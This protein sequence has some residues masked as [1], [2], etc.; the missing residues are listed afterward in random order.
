MEASSLHGLT[1]ASISQLSPE[2]AAELLFLTTEEVSS[3]ISICKAKTA[4]AGTRESDSAG[5]AS[6]SSVPQESDSVAPTE[7]SAPAPAVQTEEEQQASVPIPPSPPATPSPHIPAPV[8]LSSEASV[9]ITLAVSPVPPPASEPILAPPTPTA[10]APPPAAVPTSAPSLADAPSSPRPDVASV[11]V[12][13]PVR[14]STPIVETVVATTDS[15]SSKS[16][17]LRAVHL[18]VEGSAN[19]ASQAGSAG[20]SPSYLRPTAATL[21]RSKREDAQPPP[22]PVVPVTPKRRTL[23]SRIMGST[24]LAPTANFLARMAGGRKPAPGEHHHRGSLCPCIS[25]T[26]GP[27]VHAAAAASGSLGPCITVLARAPSSGGPRPT[28]R[29]QPFTLTTELRPKGQPAMS[30]EELDMAEAKAFIAELEPKGQPAMRREELDMVEAKAFIAELEPK[31]QPA[32][33]WA[34]LDTAEAKVRSWSA[35]AGQVAATRRGRSCLGEGV[36]QRG[37]SFDDAGRAACHDCHRG[38]GMGRESGVGQFAHRDP[39]PTR[40]P[41]PLGAGGGADRTLAACLLAP[42]WTAILSQGPPDLRVGRAGARDRAPSPRIPPLLRARSLSLSSDPCATPEHAFRRNPVPR[43]IHESRELEF[44][45]A[46]S[47]KLPSQVCVPFHLA[48]LD[49]HTKKQAEI[50]AKAEELERREGEART[51]KARGF[52]KTLAQGVQTPPKPAPQAATTATAFVSASEKRSK[53]YTEVLE[54]V[55][56]AREAEANKDKL[57][58]D[59]ATRALEGAWDGTTDADKDKLAEEIASRSL[60]D[61]GLDQFRKTLEFKAAAM[62]DFSSPFKPSASKARGVTQSQEFKFSTDDRLGP[63]GLKPRDDREGAGLGHGV[64]DGSGYHNAFAAN[65]RSSRNGGFLRA[66]MP[67]SPAAAAAAAAGSPARPA[68]LLGSARSQPPTPPPAGTVVAAGSGSMRRRGGG[69]GGDHLTG[70]TG[71]RGRVLAPHGSGALGRLQPVTTASQSRLWVAPTGPPH[72]H[73]VAQPL[74]LCPVG[75]RHRSANY[76]S[77]ATAAGAAYAS[78][79]AATAAA[80]AAARSAKTG[81]AVVPAAAAGKAAGA[82]AGAPPAM[83]SGGE[84]PRQLLRRVGSAV[85][86]N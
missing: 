34:E 56:R 74:T 41:G 72:P 48:S 9:A 53:H 32:M 84:S 40:N 79:R 82:G 57:V 49:L 69:G 75:P 47:P 1:C 37:V 55:R 44:R 27:W 16:L 29:P 22:P 4:A 68:R 17:A 42:P 33:S 52:D 70:A 85:A 2:R 58:E 20:N 39:L 77:S 35:G 46:S 64:F 19:S 24:L 73:T 83:A 26:G 81:L 71:Q 13:T 76:K 7:A 10:A 63:A 86:A 12:S 60:K 21:A 65:L 45:A 78:T 30:S 14:G 3:L 23:F 54:P 11:E 43:H 50:K 5:N 66:S 59:A 51:F 28:T 18:R 36:R 8:I 38:R 25:T 31:G 80:A 15:F 6:W 67:A 62:P 61:L